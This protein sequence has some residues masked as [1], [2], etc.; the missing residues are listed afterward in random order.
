MHG[1]V[2]EVHYTICPPA[3][4]PSVQPRLVSA[5]V[6]W[7]GRVADEDAGDVFKA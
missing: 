6:Q 5:R 1:D 4:L 2:G 3:G 7:I